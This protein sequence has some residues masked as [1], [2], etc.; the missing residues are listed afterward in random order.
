MVPIGRLLVTIDIYSETIG[1]YWNTIDDYWYLLEDYW[2]LLELYW[3]LLVPTGSLFLIIGTYW[4]TIGDYCWLLV[5][6]VEHRRISTIVTQWWNSGIAGL[7]YARGFYSRRP[8]DVCTKANYHYLRFG[9][10][11]IHCT[12]EI[13]FYIRR[14]CS[15]PKC[16]MY[17]FKVKC[18]M[19]IC[20][21]YNVIIND[22]NQSFSIE[23]SHLY[24]KTDDI[25]SWLRK[26]IAANSIIPFP[27]LRFRYT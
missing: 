23:C 13:S 21:W 26:K 20:I 10:H 16:P 4:K 22:Y 14:D 24:T 27:Q 3:Q 7:F 15:H 11:W 1:T 19:Y 8:F 5:L 25:R 9:I 18:Y 12:I 6:N 2:Y 17:T